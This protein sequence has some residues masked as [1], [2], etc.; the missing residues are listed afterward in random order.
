MEVIGR[1]QGILLTITCFSIE[2]KLAHQG[3]AFRTLMKEIDYLYVF[4]TREREILV[5]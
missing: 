5:V 2:R 1:V 4:D 3:A